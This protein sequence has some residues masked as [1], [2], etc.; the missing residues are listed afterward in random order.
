MLLKT[1]WTAGALEGLQE[2]G[3]G[4]RGLGESAGA[5]EGVVGTEESL[6]LG[7]LSQEA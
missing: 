2:L 3:K 1:D 4:L 6:T 7:I 5:W